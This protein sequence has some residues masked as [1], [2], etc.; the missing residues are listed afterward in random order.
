[1][2]AK[3]FAQLFPHRPPLTAVKGV[4]GHT[5]G[6]SGLVELAI[7]QE[8]LRRQQVP[9]IAGLTQSDYAGIN[10]VFQKSL[11]TPQP[12]H[13]VLKTASGFGGVNAAVIVGRCGA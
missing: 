10:P 4:L 6:A 13:T 11:W 9:P 3:V 7:A 8:M 5:L 2:E 12:I 1:M